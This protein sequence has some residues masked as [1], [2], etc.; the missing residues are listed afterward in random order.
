MHI[1]SD[2]PAKSCLAFS[3]IS[4]LNISAF[5]NMGCLVMLKNK[6][7]VLL[8]IFSIF[9]ANLPLCAQVEIQK[10]ESQEVA[11]KWLKLIDE[12]KYGDSWDVGSLTFRLTIPKKHWIALM[13]QIRAPLGDVKER[14]MVD[15]RPASNPKGLPKG[16]YMVL[17]FDTSFSEKQKGRELVTMVLESDGRWR[18]L[19]YQVQ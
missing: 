19:T 8:F 10:L 13:Q 16:D 18:V 1:F 5:K 6:C 2:D 14:K 4:Q 3:H 11:V 7:S 17:V 9:A 12:G 15:Q